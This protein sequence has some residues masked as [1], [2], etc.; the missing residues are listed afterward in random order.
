MSF[1]FDSSFNIPEE[2]FQDITKNIDDFKN[3][4]LIDIF[5]PRFENKFDPCLEWDLKSEMSETFLNQSS[6]QNLGGK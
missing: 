4:E 5:K 1:N 2:N 3:S 6:S